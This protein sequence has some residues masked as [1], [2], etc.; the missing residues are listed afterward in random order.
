M[1]RRYPELGSA[2]VAL[3]G[4]S[5]AVALAVVVVAA[6]STPHPPP[7]VSVTSPRPGPPLATAR[8]W[9]YQLQRLDPALID[10][11]I[12][13]LVTDPSRDGSDAGRWSAEEVSA[14]RRRDG[15]APRILLAYLSIGEAEAY[16]GYWRAHWRVA[17]PSWL[18]RENPEWKGNFAVRYWEPGWQR[19]H[20]DPEPTFLRRVVRRWLPGLL[21][22]PA[23]DRILAA[24]FEGVYLDKV[25]GF[26]D[27]AAER[28]AAAEEM[29]DFVESI[30]A[31]AKARRPGFLVVP[32]NGEELLRR[33]SYVA[34][35]DGIAKEDLRF[36]VGGDGT[37]NSGD[38]LAASLAALAL[39][40]AAGR[41]VFQ[42]EYLDDPAAMRQAT[43][44]AAEDGFRLLFARRGLD[45]PPEL[46]PS[47]G[48]SAPHP[49]GTASSTGPSSR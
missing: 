48:L 21:P 29:A 7:A 20:L 36:G 33:P 2:R 8:I 17:P 34:A 24:G 3:L 19:L 45:L 42:V 44:R 37:P 46:P 47:A 15:A 32:Q 28:P 1:M 43:D 40:T 22:I 30:S 26:E 39:A 6:W 23:L 49:A 31:Y 10:P 38:D 14:L 16:R 4:L 9:G 41:P 27:W 35:I 12:D 5:A 11:S 13:M 25:D 18:G